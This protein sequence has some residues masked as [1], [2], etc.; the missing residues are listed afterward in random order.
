MATIGP[1]SIADAQAQ[2]LQPDRRRELQR[3]FGS[4][5][6]TERPP[7]SQSSGSPTLLPSTQAELRRTFGLSV[8]K[9]IRM[10]ATP[11]TT[12]RMQQLPLL[13]GNDSRTYITAW[14]HIALDVTAVDHS[15]T[16]D[17]NPNSYHQQGG[18]A[19]TSRALAL[20]HLAIFEAANRPNGSPYTSM[21]FAD[22]IAPDADATAAAITEAT[23]QVLL[24]LYPGLT[25]PPIPVVTRDEQRCQTSNNVSLR[26]YNYCAFAAIQDVL[27]DQQKVDKGAEIG[28][29]VAERIK[30]KYAG[31]GSQK[32]EPVWYSDFPSRTISDPKQGFDILQWQIDPVSKLQVALGGRWSDVKPLTMTSSFQFRKPEAEFPAPQILGKGP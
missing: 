10:T 5:G 27:K 15:P 21:L 7:G 24:W 23:F 6:A 4:S 30:D 20:V 19:R 16:P 2:I 13:T 14:R 17:K 11:A 28:R 26:E 22:Q 18:P 29:Q 25:E 3:I 31:D 9:D 1:A 12:A 8:A 32:T